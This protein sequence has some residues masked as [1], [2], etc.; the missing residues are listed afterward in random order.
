[1][2]KQ[3]HINKMIEEAL[4]SVDDVKRAEARPFLLTRIHARMSKGTESV[5]EKA[6]WLITR[7]VVAFTGLCLIVLINVM[8][9]MNNNA[10][11]TG[12]ANDQV[13]LNSTD[14]FSSTVAT[15]YDIENTQ[16]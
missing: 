4:T 11:N 2:N 8:V 12:N 6:G 15:I 13:A 3:E 5:W 9:M 16:P 14:E 1:M 7:P 10:V